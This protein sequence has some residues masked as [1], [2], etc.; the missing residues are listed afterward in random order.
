M[1]A[2][3]LVLWGISPKNIDPAGTWPFWFNAASGWAF[4]KF[5]ALTLKIGEK[6]FPRKWIFA[7]LAV[8]PLIRCA[9][10]AHWSRAL[11]YLGCTLLGV[12]W[13][14]IEERKKENS[15]I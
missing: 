4:W 8:I 9:V 7:L 5:R 2:P 13:G 15:D 1:L 6:K 11:I 10:Q 14:L 12:L 3:A